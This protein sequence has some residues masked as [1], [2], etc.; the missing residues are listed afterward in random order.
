MKRWHLP[1]HNVTLESLNLKALKKWK[2][3]PND[4]S[5]KVN[6]ALWRV[7]IQLICKMHKKVIIFSK[8]V[9]KIYLSF[10]V[11]IIS[12]DIPWNQ[13]MP[14]IFFYVR[15][16]CNAYSNIIFIF[17]KLIIS[18]V[19]SYKDL[20]YREL[21]QKSFIVLQ[22]FS[23]KPVLFYYCF[24]FLH[25]VNCVFVVHYSDRLVYI[26]HCVH[27][28]LCTLYIVYI[29]HCVHCTLCTLYIVCTFC[30]LYI[31]GFFY[32]WHCKYIYTT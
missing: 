17:C 18:N 29:V 7:R 12:S 5:D 15:E 28:T 20:R 32:F 26:V 30:T 4:W 23:G 27:C 3:L 21:E 8:C 31:V 25:G 2:Y 11:C 14:H 16:K 6:R 10:S 22:S 24:N 9:F 1:I 19:A 13:I